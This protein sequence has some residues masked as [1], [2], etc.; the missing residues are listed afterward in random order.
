M[1]DPRQLPGCYWQANRPARELSAPLAGE[2]KVDVAVIGAGYTGLAAAFHL[3]AADPGLSVAILESQAAGYGASGRNAGFVVTLFGLGV[4]VMKAM[5]GR[6]RVRAAHEAMVRAKAGLE[7]TITE[8]AIDC[9]YRR[10][11]FLKVA[12]TPAY[13]S[14]IRKEVDFFQSLGIDGSEWI[15]GEAVRARVRSPTYIGASWEPGCALLHP[16]KWVD[17]LTR[18]ACARGALLFEGTRVE[19][20]RREGGRYRLQTPTGICVAE[21]VVFATNGYTHLIP[22]MRSKQI[23][24]F[25]YAVATAPLTA[26][27]RAAIGWA[28]EEGVEDARNFMHFYRLTPDGR[29]LVGGGTG[30][31]PFAGNMDNDSA[32]EAWNHAQR[33]I[34]ETFPPLRGI[35]IDYRW[36]GAFSVTSDSTPQ[37]GTLDGEASHIRS[38]A[39]ATALP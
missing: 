31:V 22:G 23:P 2:I 34:E 9:D 11:G 12:T 38:D 29:I 26:D 13:A 1:T 8:N 7:A 6:E 5:H 24:A 16:V 4:L 35:G 17:G 18:L 15:D 39:T 10:N 21:K 32:P 37:V 19:K 20:V 28:G 30:L 14:R 27:Q 33:F 25:V 3:K 36:G